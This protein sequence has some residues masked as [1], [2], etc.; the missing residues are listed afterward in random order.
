MI[1]AVF[2][3]FYRTLC[4]WDQ[5]FKPRLQKI[6][7]RYE[8]KVNWTHYASAREELDKNSPS[9]GPATHNILETIRCMVDSY[10]DF[11]T[12]LG[13]QDYLHQIA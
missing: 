7:D 8:V 2:F 3:H 11:L 4:I 13:V 10:R 1:K 12:T 5:P 9:S 6:P